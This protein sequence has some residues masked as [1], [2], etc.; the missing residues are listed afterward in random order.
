MNH[1]RIIVFDRVG[2]PIAIFFN[3]FISGG[4]RNAWHAGEAN[5][6]HDLWIEIGCVA[7]VGSIDVP[8]CLIN[9]AYAFHGRVSFRLNVYS[10]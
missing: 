9:F 10:I 1:K 3:K 7:M 8:R 4:I 2:I 6:N 5:L